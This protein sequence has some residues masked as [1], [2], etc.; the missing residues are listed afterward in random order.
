MSAKN[1][2]FLDFTSNQHIGQIFYTKQEDERNT[3]QKLF[4]F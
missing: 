1:I 2:W 3:F 4:F